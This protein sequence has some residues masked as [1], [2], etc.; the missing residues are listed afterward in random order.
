MVIANPTPVLEGVVQQPHNSS[1]MPVDMGDYVINVA[2]IADDMPVWGSAPAARDRR[3]REFWIQEPILAGAIFTT[4]AR[5]AAFG[6]SLKGPPRMVALVERMLHG[7]EFGK[8]WLQFILKVLIDL[9]TQDN[10][11]FIEIIR[12]SDS[13]TAP[14]ISLKHLDSNRCIR[15]G[16]ALE[17]VWYY[18][19]NNRAHLL[20]WYQVSDLT[21]CPSPIEEA[22]GMQYCTVSRILKASQIIRDINTYE[23]EKISGRFNGALHLVSGVT[24]STINDALRQHSMQADS[25]GLLRYIQ[26]VVIAALDPTKS[27]SV[28]TVPLASLPENFQKD[29][30]FKWY[31]TQLA[32][33]FGADYQDFA[34]LPGGNLGSAQQ[35][36]TLHLKSRGKGPRLFMSMLEHVFNFHGLLPSNV[37]FQF[38]DQ[39]VAEDMQHA[40]LTLN[41]AQELAARIMSMEITPEVARQIAVDRGDYDARYLEQFNESDVTPV[42]TGVNAESNDPV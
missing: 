16:R 18:D 40:R 29:D 3:L 37:K 20:K 31:I 14:V 27:V 9:L 11:A 22:R 5:Y 2:H 8:G 4:I 10:G 1:L 30:A 23:R 38:G 12:A 42:G 41:H 39:D 25:Q 19:L 15:T 34:P 35:S 33:A 28:A 6:W 21:E 26:P 7:V 32:L 17:P 13:P 24:M 36:E